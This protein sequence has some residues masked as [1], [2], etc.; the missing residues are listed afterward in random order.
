MIDDLLSAFANG[1]APGKRWQTI[2][3]A[4]TVASAVRTMAH[5]LNANFPEV[6]TLADLG[7]EVW[8]AWRSSKDAARWPGQVNTMRALLSE[9]PKLPESTRRAMRAKTTKPRKRLPKNDAYSNTEFTAIRTAARHRVNQ[10]LRRIEANSAVLRSYADGEETPTMVFQSRGTVWTPGSL[11]Q[12]LSQVG[13][14]PSEY[15]AARVK[16][17]GAFD[18]RG[19]TNPAQALFPSINEI[20]CLMVLLVCE[21][22]FN[23]SVMANL[24]VSSFASSDQVTESSV[25]T[26]SIDKPRRGRNRHSDEILAGEAGKLWD[27]AVQLTQPCRDALRALG[28]PTDL[29][30]IAHRHKDLNGLGP[31]RT[32]WSHLTHTP[33]R[34]AAFS[35]DGD[36]QPIRIS[37]QRLRLTEQILSQ[38]A[39]QNSEAVSEDTYRRLD[40]TTIEAASETV[41]EAQIDAVNHA[42]ATVQVRAMTAADVAAARQDPAAVA[43]SFSVPV[44]TLNLLL[45]GKLDTPTGACIDYFNGPFSQGAGEPCPASFFACFACGNSV[46]TPRHLPRLVVLLDA[47]DAI[48]TVVTPRR[49][50][51]DYAPHYARLRSV[52]TANA[53]QPEIDEARRAI[54]PAERDMIARLVTRSLDA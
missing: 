9:S 11:L 2:S 27:R 15:L 40:P 17:K 13:M 8:W 42:I 14:L 48:A 21:R 6:T 30:L 22:G 3:T 12:H 54:E 34:S 39:R 10:A 35:K 29:L 26:V 24:T 44:T 4:T 20:Y 49:W 47:L 23:L 38:H 31:F 45:A 37:F 28:T 51:S 33:A 53:T 46:I 50:D 41:E 16:L 5:Y 7:A 1:A 52:L 32:D 18:L 43:A 19:V 36:G 25:H